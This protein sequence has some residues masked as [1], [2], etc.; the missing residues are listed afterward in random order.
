M[1]HAV[2]RF[3]DLNSHSCGMLRTNAPCDIPCRTFRALDASRRVTVASMGQL[4][5]GPNSSER[6]CSMA[7][8][9]DADCV[10]LC[11]FSAADG[12]RRDAHA[13]IRREAQRQTR[14]DAGRSCGQAPTLVARTA[15]TVLAFR[16]CG[17]G[18]ARG[19]GTAAI[20]QSRLPGGRDGPVSELPGPWA[21]AGPRVPGPPGRLI[22]Y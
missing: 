3:P 5:R 22:T 6:V 12:F 8:R 20:G 14:R 13:D 2:P 15:V 17:P 9:N 4:A 7:C 16:S 11:C 19:R 1:L 10:R 18:R 21:S